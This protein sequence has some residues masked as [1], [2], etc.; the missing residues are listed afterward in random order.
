MHLYCF[1]ILLSGGKYERSFYSL[2]QQ[3]FDFKEWVMSKR[4]VY[5]ASYHA[6]YPYEQSLI[7]EIFVPIQSIKER[8]DD[9]CVRFVKNTIGVHIRRTD[10]IASIQ[11]SPME[12]FFEKV[13]EELD[14]DNLTMVYLA[15]DSEEVKLQMKQRYGNRIITSST[16][17]DR[18]SVAGIQDSLIDMYTLART[19]KIYGSF[20][21]S[22]SEMASQIG[23]TPLEILRI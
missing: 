15:T 13:D 23:G 7:G 16:S 18:K 14:K 12:L 9:R 17:A 19:R 22:F 10:N 20:Q 2:I 1:N 11:Q 3:N 4:K 6:F 21:S 8:I 5:M